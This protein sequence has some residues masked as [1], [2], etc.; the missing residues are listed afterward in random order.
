MTR[1]QWKQVKEYRDITYHKYDGVA[2]IAFD[3]PGLLER[4]IHLRL[5][6]LSG[7]VID[8]ETGGAGREA[9]C[10]IMAYSSDRMKYTRDVEKEGRFRF[11]GIPPGT[12]T[13]GVQGKG[14]AAAWLK[15]IELAEDQVI[16]DL[17]ILM[18]LRGKLRLRISG[19][20]G[21][22]VTTFKIGILN[23][24][25][26]PSSS[27]GTNAVVKK[28]IWELDMPYRIGSWILVIEEESLGSVERPVEILWNETT[29]VSVERA[30]F[31]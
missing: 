7:L 31:R 21:T 29:E 6:E 20:E 23:P 14:F 17:R 2:R 15:D 30:D 26:I 3:R 9:D 8:E 18:P 19:L 16:N 25:G 27:I 22:G 28:G 10:W 24:D 5:T 11:K 13:L 12:Y 4:D 1:P